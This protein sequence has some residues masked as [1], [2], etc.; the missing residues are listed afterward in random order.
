MQQ[1][2]EV[3][4]LFPIPLYIGLI[5]GGILPQELAYAQ[6]LEYDPN[7]G[8]N[9]SSSNHYVLH[10][11]ELARLRGIAEHH[12]D[13][14][15]QQ[16]LATDND[17]YITQS[18][19]NRNTRGSHHH[20]HNHMNSIVS[21]VMYFTHGG[22]VPPIV[23]K[24]DRRPQILPRQTAG[25]I[26]NSDTFSFRPQGP[27]MLIFPSN[28]DHSVATNPND[29]ERISLAFNTFL[30]GDLGVEERLNRLKL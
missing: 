17:L 7:A 13:N 6:N 28:I 8:G 16:I 25:N 12:L 18:W 20:S 15:R 5:D 9:R 22:N 1:D 19:T 11:P 26:F 2:H 23:F 24:S 21:G 29:D 10:E 30:R 27:V 3:L 4:T 14:F